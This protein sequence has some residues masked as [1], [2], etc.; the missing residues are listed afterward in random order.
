MVDVHATADA[1]LS[2][3]TV[4]PGE[5]IPGFWG[6][7]TNFALVV[8]HAVDAVTVTATTTDAGATLA[9][10]ARA[11]GAARRRG[12]SRLTWVGR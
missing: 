12:R 6:V 2:G 9:I 5:M 10:R 1:T 11:L 3:L 7:R 8:G 4:E